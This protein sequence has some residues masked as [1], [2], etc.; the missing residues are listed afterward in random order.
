MGEI[1][2]EN[3][4]RTFVSWFVCGCAAGCC[5]VPETVFFWLGGVLR[6]HNCDIFLGSVE[7]GLLV[8]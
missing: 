2:E 6:C 7:R 5:P 8:V 1:I 4:P 3:S